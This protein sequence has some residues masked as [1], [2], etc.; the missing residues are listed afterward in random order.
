MDHEG[1]GPSLKQFHRLRCHLKSHRTQ[2]HVR[3]EL[4][5]S[6]RR[7]PCRV[8]LQL[9]RVDNGRSLVVLDGTTLGA[10]S[11]DGH[12]NVHRFL[13]GD[14]AEND[15]FVVKPRGD[16]G[17]DEELRAVGVR[18]SVGHGQQARLVVLQ[19]EVLVGELLA[20]DGLATR[21]VTAGEVTTLEHELRDDSVEG[22]TLVAEALLAGTESSEVLSSLRDVI[23]EEVEINAA[24]LL[25][26]SSSRFALA[27]ED[28]A[29]PGDVE[30]DFLGHV[31]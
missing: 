20:V 27:V 22:R 4:L 19:L 7:G 1:S 15:V 21:A 6:E 23:V 26:D 24:G 30:E 17:G 5:H 11:L 3:V 8:L 2:R 9:A 12:D 28:G 29:L 16:D 14:L 25:F 31:D 18:T 10:G 13:V